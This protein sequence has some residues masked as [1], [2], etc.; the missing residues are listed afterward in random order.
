MARSKLPDRWN[1]NTSLT[2]YDR[3]GKRKRRRYYG[4]DGRA[5]K[6]IDYQPHHGHP[7]PHAHDWD[8][9]KDPPRQPARLLKPGE[10]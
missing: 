7:V 5:V 1:A 4:A 6:N 10:G 9:T 3:N 2:E 8:W